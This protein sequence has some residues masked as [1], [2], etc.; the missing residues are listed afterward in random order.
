M[1]DTPETDEELAE[2]GFGFYTMGGLPTDAV[3]VEFARKLERECNDL[4][5]I[6]P[7]I[8]EAL[9][10]GACASTCSVDFLREIPR[11]VRLVRQRLERERD[12]AKKS[13]SH[14]LNQVGKVVL[15]IEEIKNERDEAVRSCHI[16]QDGH[17][18][19][20]ADRDY[21]RAEAE[22]WR[23]L[24]YNTEEHQS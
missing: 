7:K 21:W 4:R 10:S 13:A 22:R 16:W 11:E 12:T 5:D 2:L 23:D 15:R 24:S 20:V 3:K 17:S 19:I 8:L 6:F 1:S 9:E 14:C 18:K